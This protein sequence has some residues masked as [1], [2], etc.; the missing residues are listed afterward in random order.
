MIQAQTPVSAAPYQVTALG[1]SK[2]QNEMEL[3]LVKDR[4]YDI[5]A[6]DE[7]GLW[8]QAVDTITGASSLP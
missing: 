4:A 1:T 2:P 3:A 8:Y 6:V 5:L 7:A